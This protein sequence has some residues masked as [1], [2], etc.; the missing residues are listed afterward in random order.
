MHPS[1]RPTRP[2]IRRFRIASGTAFAALIGLIAGSLAILMLIVKYKGMTYARQLCARRS[3]AAGSR[4]AGYAA[5][6][7]STGNRAFDEYREETLKRLEQEAGDFRAFLD[8]LRHA[9]DK[10][11]FDQYMAERRKVAAAGQQTA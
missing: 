8:R 2:I 1:P 6:P 7:S 10:A 5:P 3:S 9:K 11:D 4:S